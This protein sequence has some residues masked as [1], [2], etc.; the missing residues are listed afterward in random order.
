M[1]RASCTGSHGQGIWES[2]LGALKE[3][4]VF[5]PESSRRA[6]CCKGSR[7]VALGTPDSLDEPHC[8]S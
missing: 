1:N 3:N 7:Q 5:E 8:H 6:A 4:V 2:G